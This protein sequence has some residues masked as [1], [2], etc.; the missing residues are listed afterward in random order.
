MSF[1]IRQSC[2]T[3]DI[4]FREHMTAI[5]CGIV[6]VCVIAFLFYRSIYAVPILLPLVWCF[7]VMWRRGKERKKEMEFRRQFQDAL[8]YLITSLNVGYSIEGA[9]YETYKEL[10]FV[11]T[12]DKRIMKEW[13]RMLHQLKI[14]QPVEQV[15][16]GLVLRIEQE[17]VRNFVFIFLTAKRGGGDLIAI[18]KQTIFQIQEKERTEQEIET[19]ISA[20][21]F[22]FHIM[23]LVPFG[24]IGYMSVSFPVFLQSLYHNPAGVCVMSIC[25]VIYGGAYL[26]GRYLLQV[27]V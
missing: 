4:S 27:Q 21:Q 10:R 2:F 17:D 15:L 3:Q 6:L 14:N 18:L 12:A 24:M 9:M 8:Q 5:V 19:I 7:Y 22:E 13:E 26:L 11:Y 1:R 23:A 16:E 25:L 20:K